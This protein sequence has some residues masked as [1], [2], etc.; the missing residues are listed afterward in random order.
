M[1]SEPARRITA[2]EAAS[3]DEKLP[4]ISP[5][6]E[7]RSRIVGA[8]KTLP[9]RMMASGAPMFASVISPKRSAPSAFQAKE[10]SH[11]DLRLS[12]C[13]RASAN[14]EPVMAASFGTR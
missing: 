2:R 8:L 1:G 11:S 3:S 12:N 9:S 4:V 5:F 14:S 10:T 13:T 6:L 7:M